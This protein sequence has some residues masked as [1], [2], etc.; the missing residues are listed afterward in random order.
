MKF[1]SSPPQIIDL[2]HTLHTGVPTWSGS[3]GFD[4]KVK[5]DYSDCEGEVKFR[6][7]KVTMHCGIGTHIDAPSHCLRDGI[8]CHEIPLSQLL[9]PVV[10][11]DLSHKMDEHLL[12]SAANILDFEKKHGQIAAGTLAILNTGW[13]RFWNEPKKYRNDGQFPSVSEEAAKLLFERGAA[14]LAIDTL[15]PDAAKSNYPAHKVFLHGG[16]YIIEN[17]AN[18][19]L[20]PPTGATVIA[21]PMKMEGSTEAPIRMIA[22]I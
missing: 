19:D 16:R 17:V 18:A 3:C 14:G 10:M 12:V 6:A 21:L 4:I 1:F 9:G 13:S 2:T 22:L 8:S 5:C 11:I 20:L 15:S 7:Q